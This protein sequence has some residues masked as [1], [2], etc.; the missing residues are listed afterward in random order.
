MGAAATAR[1]YSRRLS[2]RLLVANA[3]QPRVL[4]HQSFQLCLGAVSRPVIDVN[5]L[6]GPL[7]FERFGDFSHKQRNIAGLIADRH[8]N[9]YRRIDCIHAAMSYGDRSPRAT[10]LMR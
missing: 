8:H 3:A 4:R 2:A 5:D 7:P 1:P 6:E 10:A 9:G